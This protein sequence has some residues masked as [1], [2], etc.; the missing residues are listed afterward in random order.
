ME[1]LINFDEI[2]KLDVDK[3][4][5]YDS[6]RQQVYDD[7]FSNL[8]EIYSSLAFST[9]EVAWALT[10]T[11]FGED[12]TE[13][14]EARQMYGLSTEGLIRGS[15]AA[16]RGFRSSVAA[17]VACVSGLSTHPYAV[18]HRPSQQDYVEYVTLIQEAARLVLQQPKDWREIYTQ[19]IVSGI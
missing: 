19:R 15:R 9:S 6:W 18:M 4:A 3:L 12:G 17:S 2:K 7:L 14:R 16:P 11:V 8:G 13:K 5:Q 1:T 10:Q